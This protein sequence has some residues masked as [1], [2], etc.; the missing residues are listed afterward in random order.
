MYPISVDDF[1]I[2]EVI[3]DDYSSL[4]DGECGCSEYNCEICFGIPPAIWNLHKSIGWIC[5]YLLILIKGSL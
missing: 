1:I 3:L 2:Q 4:L 5:L